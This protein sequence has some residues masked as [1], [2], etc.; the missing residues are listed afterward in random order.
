MIPFV[1]LLVLLLLV[2]TISVLLGSAGRA[3]RWT[4]TPREE[5]DYRYPNQGTNRVSTKSD[6]IND[7]ATWSGR[8]T[9][10]CGNVG[11]DT[12]P[13]NGEF[14]MYHYCSLGSGSGCPSTGCGLYCFAETYTCESFN[15]CGASKSLKSNPSTISCDVETCTVDECCDSK[16]NFLFNV[17]VILL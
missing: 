12:R 5:C 11:I 8:S 10:Q 13:T 7:L 2:P 4:S 9:N 6:T 16:A 17:L 15:T 3:G 1:P 14:T